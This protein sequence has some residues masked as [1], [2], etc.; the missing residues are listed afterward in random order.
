MTRFVLHIGLSKTGTS[1]LQRAVFPNHSQVFYLG[2]DKTSKAPR[3]CRSLPVHQLLELLLWTKDRQESTKQLQLRYE[4]LVL[5]N[6]ADRNC[7]LGSWEAL[8]L[9]STSAFHQM[10]ERLTAVVGDC[11]VIVCLRH[12]MAWLE[13][14]YIQ[15]VKG[16]FIYQNRRETF[17]HRPYMTIDE[18]LQRFID[19]HIEHGAFTYVENIRAAA[20]TLGYRNVKVM[21]FEAL[22]TDSASYYHSIADFLGVDGREF[23]GLALTAHENRRLRAPQLELIERFDRSAE[24]RKSWANMDTRARR[25]ALR[26]AVDYDSE[27]YDELRIRIGAEW[28]ARI[29]ES[30]IAGNR[31]LSDQFNLDLAKYGYPL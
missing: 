18:W 22:Q 21:M 25:Q 17:G 28:E 2:K 8:G 3:G 13:S 24:L 10:I 16:Q 11:R 31:W 14:L 30:T 23:Q 15:Q 19:N 5:A 7:V 20:A 26:N 6:L 27:P 12:P 4:Q 29:A 9:E 1:T